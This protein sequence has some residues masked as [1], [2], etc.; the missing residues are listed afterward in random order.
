MIPTV[1]LRLSHPTAPGTVLFSVAII[2]PFLGD[3]SSK[4]GIALILE[5]GG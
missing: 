5:I 4:K 2:V 3:D 1:N